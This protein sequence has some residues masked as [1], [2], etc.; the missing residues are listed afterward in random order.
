[1]PAASKPQ[2]GG[3]ISVYSKDVFVT[4]PG[5]LGFANLV[6]PDDAFDSLKFKVNLHLDEDNVDRLGDLLDRHVVTPLWPKF[7]AAMEEAR[8]PAPKK[9]PSGADWLAEKMKLAGERSKIQLPYLT[10]ANNAEFRDKSGAMKRKTMMATSASGDA[11]D[12]PR[13]HLGMGS[14]VQ[15]LCRPG[16]FKNALL[17]APTISLQLQGVRVLKLVQFGGG[18]GNRVGALSQED[19]DALGGDFVADELSQFAKGTGADTARSDLDDEDEA[20]RGRQ[21]QRHFDSDL[22]DEIPF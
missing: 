3:V 4:S 6:E 22:D 7:L 14:T 11:L 21:R 12:L 9:A 18:G 13:L 2:G 1:M 20:P 5:T 17:P 19:L 8:K 15:V 16:L 10:I